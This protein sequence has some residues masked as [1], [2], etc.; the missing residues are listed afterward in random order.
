MLTVYETVDLGLITMFLKLNH[1]WLSIA[2][3]VHVI[4]LHLYKNVA[5]ASKILC[6]YFKRVEDA[7]SIMLRSPVSSKV[8]PMV[9]TFSPGSWKFLSTDYSHPP[10][11]CRASNPVMAVIVPNDV[12]LYFSVSGFTSSMRIVLIG[13]CVPAFCPTTSI[14]LVCVPI[15]YSKW[16]TACP[17]IPG[18]LGAANGPDLDRFNLPRQNRRN[19]ASRP[20]TLRF[21]LSSEVSEIV[22][23]IHG[24]GSTYRTN[25]RSK[26]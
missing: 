6:V 4:H 16:P 8:Q 25:A 1:F 21:F 24:V 15:G 22:T 3:G 18:A 9:M 12:H 7:L 23:L 2:S 5:Y 17:H 13:Q 19:P 10:S 26:L 14:K 20:D 11:A